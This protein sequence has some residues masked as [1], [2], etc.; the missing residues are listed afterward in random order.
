MISEGFIILNVIKLRKIHSAKEPYKN[1]KCLL[2]RIIEI[3]FF[4]I[5]RYNLFNYIL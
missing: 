3:A 5:L 2:I 1:R 4:L